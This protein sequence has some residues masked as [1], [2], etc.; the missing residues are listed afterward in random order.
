MAE[1]ASIEKTS[2]VTRVLLIGSLTLNFLF[3]G[4]VVGFALKAGDH[5]Q[6]PA[7]S[8]LIGPFT[9]ALDE[10]QRDNVR[11]H[12]K[13]GMESRRKADRREGRRNF[14]VL[15]EA[16]RQEPFDR[17]TV[18][19]ALRAMEAQGLDRRQ[20]GTDALLDA[21]EG[22][23]VEERA[24][25]IDRLEQKLRKVRSKPKKRHPQG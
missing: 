15:M 5:R 9:Q 22:L 2:R 11:E 10:V 23:S 20:Q 17:A 7:A 13:K 6:P 18:E 3:V 8:F 21:I 25:Y 12:L 24:E 19:K 14:M 16:L 1:N 4:G